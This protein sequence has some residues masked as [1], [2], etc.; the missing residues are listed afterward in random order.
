M[1]RRP[2]PQGICTWSPRLDRIGNSMRGVAFCRE[3]VNAYR[4]HLYDS[5]LGSGTC[6][7]SSPAVPLPR[8]ER[9][10]SA[11]RRNR[12]C[13]P[14]P[15]RLT[16][17]PGSAWTPGGGGRPPRVLRPEALLAGRR[18]ARRT[19]GRQRRPSPLQRSQGPSGPGTRPPGMKAAV[20]AAARARAR[21]H[22]ARQHCR[23][24]GGACR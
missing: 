10:R 8:E 22:R 24:W 11:S 23:G 14:P 18:S 15:S 1:L 19:A 4:V 7:A 3:L 20:G 5:I 17:F 21:P 6:A 16:R 12:A 9:A 2:P 13:L